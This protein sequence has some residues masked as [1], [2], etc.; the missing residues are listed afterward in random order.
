MKKTY[1][2]KAAE[3]VPV[4]AARWRSICKYFINSENRQPEKRYK[5]QQQYEEK[6]HTPILREKEIYNNQVK[7][8]IIPDST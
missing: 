7:T 5:I 8:I 3:L 1:Q 4:F 6:R 2:I